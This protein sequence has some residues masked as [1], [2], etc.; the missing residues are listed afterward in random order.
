MLFKD[1]PR[2]IEK[3]DDLSKSINVLKILNDKHIFI[4]LFL[5]IY[6]KIIIYPRYL[7]LKELFGKVYMFP[8]FFIFKI[9]ISDR[10]IVITLR[11]SS[12]IDLLR[13]YNCIPSNFSQLNSLI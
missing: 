13:D 6:Y 3:C 2:I 12:V 4:C 8:Y 1:N 11:M 9:I 5:W 7:F 10:F